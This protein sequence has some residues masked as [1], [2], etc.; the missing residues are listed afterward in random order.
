[1]TPLRSLALGL[2]A[3]ALTALMIAAYPAPLFA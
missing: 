1:M 3:F 2:T